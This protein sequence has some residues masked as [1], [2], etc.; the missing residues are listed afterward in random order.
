M[1]GDGTPPPDSPVHGAIRTAIRAVA[2]NENLSGCDNEP[3]KNIGHTLLGK[4]KVVTATCSLSG[5]LG[6][7]PVIR[8]GLA[9]APGQGDHTA[10]FSIIEGLARLG[11]QG[12]VELILKFNA[13]DE[14]VRMKDKLRLFLPEFNP[15]ND[16]VQALHYSGLVCECI[17]FK[18]LADHC[19][20]NQR[21]L[22][23]P[24]GFWAMNGNRSWLL[25]TVAIIIPPFKW[26]NT[27]PRIERC[28]GLHQNLDLPALANYQT[29][30]I[31]EKPDIPQLMKGDSRAASLI[32][33][34]RE[35][36]AG[37]IHL[38]PVYGIHH[39]SLE[40]AHEV[41]IKRLLAG[42]VKSHTSE[43]EKTVV[44][45]LSPLECLERLQVLQTSL[46]VPFYDLHK[47]AWTRPANG[48]VELLYCGP[49]PKPL[50]EWISCVDR[51]LIQEGANSAT[52]MNLLGKAYLPLRP[53]GDTPLPELSGSPP[54]KKKSVANAERSRIEQLGRSLTHDLQ[55]YNYYSV[56][57]DL[58]KKLRPLLSPMAT[59]DLVYRFA[60]MVGVNHF[61]ET[62]FRPCLLES[63]T[64]SCGLLS[65]GQQEWLT[66]LSLANSFLP[67]AIPEALKVKLVKD[68]K[69]LR[70]NG[71]NLEKLVAYRTAG[72]HLS[73]LRLQL[74]ALS[75]RR[76]EAF[77]ADTVAC[78]VSTEDA[79]RDIDVNELV[80][81]ICDNFSLLV[82]AL[83]LI[84][85]EGFS[86]NSLLD[87]IIGQLFYGNMA[88][89][90]E[91]RSL[92]EPEE[93]NNDDLAL[94]LRGGFGG[95]FFRQVRER[96]MESKN[97][98]IYCGLS[99]LSRQDWDQILPGN[100]PGS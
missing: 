25:S 89:D 72:L 45:I 87:K 36:E 9:E 74:P 56:A 86:D 22:E 15:G 32:N 44:L 69:G 38:L 23:Q 91:I 83:F 33:V 84:L 17:P 100:A 24:L 27:T 35:T 12:R 7:I 61:D 55:A 88:H 29:T 96:M 82:P 41:I 77:R 97:N 68:G 73:S 6:A 42:A 37:R 21:P 1:E 43:S 64:Y 59:S 2:A 30:S 4:R 93:N 76:F 92:L 66:C 63:I 46:Q 39:Q 10:A 3:Q 47:T 94:F 67:E 57:L 65:E 18:R 99:Q 28:N 62:E 54:A 75:F 52:F 11:F 5:K 34:L 58:C 53:D 8:V 49:L 20:I 70:S 79:A 80:G 14:W 50:F 78:P 81:D 40:P 26:T 19:R 48:P 31:P 71:V 95:A 13:E 16:G 85:R 51:P 98:A 60:G 90:T